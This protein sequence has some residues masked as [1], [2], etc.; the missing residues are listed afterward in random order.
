[1]KDIKEYYSASSYNII[2]AVMYSDL[3]RTVPEF[4][5]RI[6]SCDDFSFGILQR[7]LFIAEAKYGPTVSSTVGST[8]R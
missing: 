8:T 6:Q 5:S 2:N 4:L 7:G 1:M 3:C